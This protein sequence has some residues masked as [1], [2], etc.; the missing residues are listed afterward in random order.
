M[1]RLV[2]VPDRPGL[3]QNPDWVAGTP[4]TF[5]MIIGVSSYDHLVGGVRETAASNYGLGQLVVSALTGYELFQWVQNDYQFAPENETPCPLAQCWLIL[6]P[7]ALEVAKMEPAIASHA[8][9]ATFDNCR[10]SMLVWHK[11]MAGLSRP[12]QE[13]SRAFFFFSGHGLEIYQDEQIV[14]L[15]DWLRPDGDVNDAINVRRFARALGETFVNNQYFF[16][17]ACRNDHPDLRLL[18]IRGHAAVTSG[19]SARANPNNAPIL[20][21]SAA[22]LQTFQPTSLEDGLSLFGQSLLDGLRAR[23]GYVP[24]CT[25][26]YCTV[27]YFSLH[28]FI[29]RRYKQ[30]LNK[31]GQDFSQTIPQGGQNTNPE[32]IITQLMLREAF[33]PDVAEAPKLE[34]VKFTR[35]VDLLTTDDYHPIGKSSEDQELMN[36]GDSEGESD[37]GT[38]DLGGM[39]GLLGGLFGNSNGDRNLTGDSDSAY[40]GWYRKKGNSRKIKGSY[41]NRRNRR[42]GAKVPVGSSPSTIRKPSPALF[43]TFGSEK[44]A[45]MWQSGRVYSLDKGVWKQPTVLFLNRVESSADQKQFRIIFSLPVYNENLWLEFSYGGIVYTFVLPKEGRMAIGRGAGTFISYLME[46][47]LDRGNGF[48]SQFRVSVSSGDTHS[49][50]LSKAMQVWTEYQNGTALTASLALQDGYLRQMI[51]DKTGSLTAACIAVLILFRA[52]KSDLIKEIWLRKLCNGFPQSPDACVVYN[53]F[54][55]T[56]KDREPDLSLLLKNLKNMS[57]RG[58]PF[59]SECFGLALRQ[60]DDLL[61]LGEL[62]VDTRKDLGSIKSWLKSARVHFCT[63]SLFSVFSNSSLSPD[64]VGKLK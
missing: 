58:I 44:M 36:Y 11:A 39:G 34:P 51:I 28:S 27:K 33:A 18:D 35:K 29:I 20:Y 17:D 42:G 55:L 31:Y 57:R 38:G 47:K 37:F 10:R 22:N 45:E 8:L 48:L 43:Q 61:D 7:T 1:S 2:P 41:S 50:S 52:G 30:L 56:Q 60:I 12:A 3:W 23:E 54:L 64:L 24:D 59:L 46:V 13:S 40:D 9:P 49:R 14:L 21:A 15:G 19:L 6:S 32:S 62:P 25:A 4:G 26:Q 5:V 16:I 53:E 63:G